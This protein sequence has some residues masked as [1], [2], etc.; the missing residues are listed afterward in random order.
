M[1]GGTGAWIYSFACPENGIMFLALWYTLG[2]LLVASLGAVLG[3]F[4]L[5]W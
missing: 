2:V 4:L 3:R 5:R 1:A